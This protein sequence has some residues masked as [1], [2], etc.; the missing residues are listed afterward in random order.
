MTVSAGGAGRSFIIALLDLAGSATED[1]TIVRD[2][3]AGIAAGA[4]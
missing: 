1:A 2:E 3:S 4:V